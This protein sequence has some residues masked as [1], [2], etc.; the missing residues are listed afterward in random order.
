M[1]KLAIRFVLGAF[2]LGAIAVGTTALAGKRPGGGG[3]GDIVCLDVWDPVVCAD[4]VTYSNQCYA[5]RAK[6]PKPCYP[7]DGGPVEARQ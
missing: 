6:A 1:K 2:V 7:G 5:D 3:G 4:G